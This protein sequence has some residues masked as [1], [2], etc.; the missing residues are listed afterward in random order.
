VISPNSD[1]ISQKL[2]FLALGTGLGEKN[3]FSRGFLVIKKIK[4]LIDS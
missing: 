1:E 4:G 3:S 2:A